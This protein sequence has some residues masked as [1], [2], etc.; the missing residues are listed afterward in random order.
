MGTG[1]QGL[2]LRLIWLFK[3]GF[4]ACFPDIQHFY[5]KAQGR[6]TDLNVGAEVDV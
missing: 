3:R 6:Q 1:K 5:H 2:F 4:D